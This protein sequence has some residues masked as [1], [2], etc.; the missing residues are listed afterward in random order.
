[1]K[2]N[3]NAKIDLLVFISGRDAICAE[4]EEKL[5]KG[6]WITLQEDKKVVCLSCSDLDHLVFLPAGDAALTRRARPHPPRGDELR[7][8]DAARVSRTEARTIV[9]KRGDDILREWEEGK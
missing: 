6:T 3:P 4:C 1:M 9:K 2:Q 5:E 7:R 8:P